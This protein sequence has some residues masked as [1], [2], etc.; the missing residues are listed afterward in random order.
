MTFEYKEPEIDLTELQLID[1][2][3]TSDE[4]TTDDE[5]EGPI[6]PPGGSTS[7]TDDDNEGPIIPPGGST[8]TTD[9]E[10]EGPVITPGSGG[11]DDGEDDFPIL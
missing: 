4:P 7:T 5:D 9:G 10:D 1:I 11:A 3:L 2:I 8:T 6:I